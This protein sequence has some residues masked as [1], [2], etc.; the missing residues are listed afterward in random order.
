MGDGSPPDR[1]RPRTPRRVALEAKGRSHQKW[2]R[3]IRA[4][5]SRGLRDNFRSDH[6]LIETKAAPL[7]I[8]AE[9]FDRIFKSNAEVVRQADLHLSRQ[10]G[11][12]TIGAQRVAQVCASATTETGRCR[13]NTR[14]RFA[15]D[16]QRLAR[17]G[18]AIERSLGNQ[19]AEKSL[20]ILPLGAA[21]FRTK[22]AS[23]HH[24][25]TNLSYPWQGN[26]S[27]IRIFFLSRIFR[28]YEA[29]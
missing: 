29:R 21:H 26:S 14:D 25:I 22:I 2:R 28:V 7:N 24:R 27:S 9:H 10:H 5:I 18:L 13:A 20:V 23:A 12:G 6:C 16:N 8:N 19:A 15:R 17:R 11:I 4:R 3:N 1:M